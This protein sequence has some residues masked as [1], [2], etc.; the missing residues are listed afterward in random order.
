MVLENLE[1]QT[2]VGTFG[3]IYDFPLSFYYMFITLFTIGYGDFYPIT[4]PGKMFIC[5]TIIYIIVYK[6]P[7]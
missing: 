7:T 2:L 6:L 5:F 1:Y 3:E 4:T